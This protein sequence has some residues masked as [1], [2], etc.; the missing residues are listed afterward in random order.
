MLNPDLNR[1]KAVY[2]F[3][4]YV[5]AEGE[6]NRYGLMGSD[7]SFTWMTLEVKCGPNSVDII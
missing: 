7:I 3:K 1:T 5:V 6:S 2:K 4:V